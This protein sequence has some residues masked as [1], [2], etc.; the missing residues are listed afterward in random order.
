VSTEVDDPTYLA[1]PY[2]TSSHFKKQSDTSGWN[3]TPC[4]VR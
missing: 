3:P 2:W 4:A 1:Q